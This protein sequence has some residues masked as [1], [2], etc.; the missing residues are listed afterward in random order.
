MDPSNQDNYVND[1]NPDQYYKAVGENYKNYDYEYVYPD[2]AGGPLDESELND[3]PGISKESIN[4]AT[5]LFVV[6]GGGFFFNLVVI[7]CIVSCKHLRRMTSAFIVHGCALDMLKC[8]YCVPFATSLLKDMA[9]N[10]CTVLGGSYV[11]I[12][13][14]S[15]FN[16]VAMICCEAYTFSE[17]NVGGEGKGSFCCVIFGVVMVYIGSIIIH[18]GPTIIGGDFNY[19]QHIGNCIFVYGTIKS[20]VV[21]AMWIVIMTIAMVGSVYYLCFFYK[22]VQAN[23]THRLASL[24]RASIQISR[25][26]ATDNNQSIRK[27]VRDSL[28]RA[29]VLITITFLFI[30]SWY[31]LFILT[32]VDPKARQPSKVYKLLTFLAWSN[33]AVNPLVYILFDRNI[34]IFRRIKCCMNVHSR[35]VD[36]DSDDGADDT[37]DVNRV[38]NT[39]SRFIQPSRSNAAGGGSM[40]SSSS[41]HHNITSSQCL[42]GESPRRTPPQTPAS[43]H[44]SRASSRNSTLNKHSN[45]KKGASLTVGA[46]GE[47]QPMP[48]G[49]FYERIGCRLCKEGEH[50][51]VEHCNLNG[52]VRKVEQHP[53]PICEIHSYEV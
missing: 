1:N 42:G 21:H 2:G 24:V 23:S 34:N 4:E 37:D 29:R 30:L 46:S 51:S 49:L 50:H 41:R 32:L 12:V 15:G 10:F 48:P 13:T 8:L 14:A 27:I 38:L 53:S 36:G 25:G 45:N 33:A 19:N 39:S 6:A 35:C 5:F 16:I 47:L 40:T 9:P 22:H 31:P 28:S 7:I 11:V 44:N 26:N 3:K 17:H 43:P 52:G 18:L 20:Y